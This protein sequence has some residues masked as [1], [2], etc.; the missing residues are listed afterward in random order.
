MQILSCQKREGVQKGVLIHSLYPDHS[1]FV[2]QIISCLRVRGAKHMPGWLFWGFFLADATA[3]WWTGNSK[4]PLITMITMC[5]AL[6]GLVSKTKGVTV[7]ILPLMSQFCHQPETIK[8]LLC[9]HGDRR[10]NLTSTPIRQM[11]MCAHGGWGG[12][13]PISC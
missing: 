6:M 10:E 12:C 1:P 5:S 11:F 9:Q 8:A 4:T 3:D 13:F 7:P 2:L